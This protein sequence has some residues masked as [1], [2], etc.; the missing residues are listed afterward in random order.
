MA[1]VCGRTYRTKMSDST[2]TATLIGDSGTETVE[3][4]LIDGLPQKSIVRPAGGDYDGEDMVWELVTDSVETPAGDGGYE[5]REA[6]RPGA[7]Y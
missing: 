5:Y 7:D 6:G 4:E 1:R 3:L 2:Y